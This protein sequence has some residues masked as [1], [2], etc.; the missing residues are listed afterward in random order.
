MQRLNDAYAVLRDP[1]RRAAYDRQRREQPLHG[2]GRPVEGEQG[3]RPGHRRERAPGDRKEP[4]HRDEWEAA[5]ARER[6]SERF[7]VPLFLV[8]LLALSGA[9]GSLKCVVEGIRSWA[10]GMVLGETAW[11]TGGR[12]DPTDKIDLDSVRPGEVTDLPAAISHDE[13]HD[14]RLRTY[15]G[16]AD[17][18]WTWGVGVFDLDRGLGPGATADL[19]CEECAALADETFVEHLATLR[20]AADLVAPDSL[21]IE[22]FESPPFEVAAVTYRGVRNPRSWL[23]VFGRLRPDGRWRATYGRTLG[24]RSW[25]PS[26]TFN[27]F[28]AGADGLVRLTV[29]PCGAEEIECEAVV[30]LVARTIRLGAVP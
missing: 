23:P 12:V 19:T 25:S 4:A 13:V 26:A 21:S 7:A 29:R 9:G 27:G 30:D 20:R 8:V 18:V 3:P 17:S 16:F 11:G 10:A 28:V 24:T 15:Q 1:D 6:M 22:R 5:D 2:P 14:R